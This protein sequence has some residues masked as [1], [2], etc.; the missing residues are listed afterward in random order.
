MP[1]IE[2]DHD[3]GP[4]CG[5]ENGVQTLEAAEY[6]EKQDLSVYSPVESIGAK[7]AS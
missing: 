1:T 4:T 5:S 3:T 6:G 7:T 2:R